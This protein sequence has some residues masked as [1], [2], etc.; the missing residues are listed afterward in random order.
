VEWA[1]DWLVHCWEEVDY[2]QY[3][4]DIKHRFE[5]VGDA[6]AVE[7]LLVVDF[8]LSEPARVLNVVRSL[9]GGFHRQEVTSLV[10]T[11]DYRDAEGWIGK[12][13]SLGAIV[14]TNNNCRFT[15]GAHKL[16][17][18]LTW[19]AA[20]WP[21]EYLCRWKRL[22]EW[23]FAGNEGTTNLGSIG[24]HIQKLREGSGGYD[25]GPTNI[26]PIDPGPNEDA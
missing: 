3:S 20:E 10:T 17:R 19:L 12:M 25:S 24:D 11:N 1:A 6:L 21:E 2:P 23:R 26:I 13:L 22:K 16:L 14:R 5:E 8:G 18:Q 9:L 4:Y 7:Q 15:T